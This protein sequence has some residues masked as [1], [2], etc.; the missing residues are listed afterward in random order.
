MS[1]NNPRAAAQETLESSARSLWTAADEAKL[2]ELQQRR[3]R[4]MAENR[5]PIDALVVRMYRAAA[6]VTT[7][8]QEREMGDFMIQNADEIAAAIAPFVLAK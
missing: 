8:A 7:D 4:I 3:D 5:K 6:S 1:S 2:A